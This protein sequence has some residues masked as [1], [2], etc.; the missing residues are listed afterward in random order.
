M[1]IRRKDLNQ[2]SLAHLNQ[3]SWSTSLIIVTRDNQRMDCDPGT[4]E[5]C[6]EMSFSLRQRSHQ[7]LK[8]NSYTMPT[9][10]RLLRCPGTRYGCL[11]IMGF[12]AHLQ[13]ARCRGWDSLLVK[14]TDA[15]SSALALGQISTIGL[16]QYLL[17]NPDETRRGKRDEEMRSPWQVIEALRQNGP[18]LTCAS[19]WLI[20]DEES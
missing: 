14:P 10:Q 20:D 11:S 16:S 6:E 19:R 4:Y 2:T 17:S 18:Q 15:T 12:V 5:N 7:P 1:A 9:H 3:Y 13:V 8:A